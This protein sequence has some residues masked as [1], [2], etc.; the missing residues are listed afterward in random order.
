MHLRSIDI[1]GR[2]LAQPVTGVQRYGRELLQAIDKALEG[3]PGLRVRLL[4]PELNE[5]PPRLKNIAHK[6]VGRLRG[7]AW[8]QLDLPRH[9]S[10]R[11]LFCPGNTAPL[12]LLGRAR[13]VV[14]VHDLSYL[15]YPDAYSLP[16]RLFYRLLIPQIL[17]KASA[18]IT[19][20][21]SERT[22]IVSYY[23]GTKNIV[24]IQNGGL[25]GGEIPVQPV[26][27]V[28]P[29]TVLYVG[30][31]SQRKNLSGIMEVAKRLTSKRDVRFVLIGG[32]SKGLAGSLTEIISHSNSRI[33]FLGQIDNWSHLQAQYRSAT[34]FFFPSFYEA[35]PLPPIEAMGCGLPVIA[36]CIPSLIE[37]CGG[38]AVYCDPESVDSM[39]RELETVL[40]DEAVQAS[41]RERGYRRA[42]EFT[43]ASCAAKTLD[44]LTAAMQ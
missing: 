32:L 8:E 9:V 37:R 12:A 4:T 40:D 22:S 2:F 30:S 17:H 1:N 35:S 28:Q 39:M 38:S 27:G 16:F 3:Q 19:V 20:S 7:H 25:P 31:L 10:G 36:S 21:E 29:T 44:V 5:P 11:V 13:V 15:Y 18:V 43:W 26:L 6:T 24:A 41:L 23:P 34:C 14:T 33:S 42:S